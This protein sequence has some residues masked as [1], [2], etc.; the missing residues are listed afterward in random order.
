LFTARQKLA[1]ERDGNKKARSHDERSDKAF[2][3]YSPLEEDH[4]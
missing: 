3:L 4:E 2:S 1:F